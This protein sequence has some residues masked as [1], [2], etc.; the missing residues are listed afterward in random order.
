MKPPKCRLCGVAHRLGD[1]HVL[2]DDAPTLDAVLRVTT[3]VT[4]H[5]AAVVA[6][7]VVTRQVEWQRKNR[8]RYNE[9][10]QARRA[11]ERG[12]ACPWPA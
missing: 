5:E 6:N 7:A 12:V 8:L 2:P 3:P 9:K 11:I 10:M 4:T 1:P